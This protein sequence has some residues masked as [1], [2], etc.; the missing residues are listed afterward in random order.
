MRRSDPK[1]A[2]TSW[3]LC[4]HL[5]A[6]KVCACDML[7]NVT[8]ELPLEDGCVKLHF[9]TFEVKTLRISR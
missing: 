6:S 7:D 8:G 1:R 3:V 5:P 9:H 4:V 2:D